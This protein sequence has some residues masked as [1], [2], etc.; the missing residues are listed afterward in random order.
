M[1][2]EIKPTLEND[3]ILSQVL[4]V[5]FQKVMKE[6]FPSAEEIVGELS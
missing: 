6:K 3:L 4:N 2:S 5:R 1:N